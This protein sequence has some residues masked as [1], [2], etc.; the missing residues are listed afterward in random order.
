[1]DIRILASI[2]EQPWFFIV[3][4]LL[5]F[6]CIVLAVI[7]VKKYAP[8]FK[9]NE[10]PK[11][12][13]EIAEEEVNRLVR[14]VEDEETAKQ[15]NEE[16]KALEKDSKS[17]D[18]SKKDDTLERKTEVVED[19]EAAKAMAK[20]AEEHPEEAQQ[21]EKAKDKADKDGK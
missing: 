9:S 13:K 21:A 4:I 19:E 15:M 17:L 5:V 10:K 11:S 18:E 14:P 16:A 12:D 1:M 2:V 7:L 3:M 6:G 8:A 20:Y